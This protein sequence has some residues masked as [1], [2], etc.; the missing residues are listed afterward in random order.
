MAKNTP[1]EAPGSIPDGPPTYPNRG[2]DGVVPEAHHGWL[3]EGQRADARIDYHAAAEETE[4]TSTG[5]YPRV[6][7]DYLHRG[8]SLLAVTC[9]ARL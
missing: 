7:R 3:L 1:R 2:I 5:K 8:V 6:S 4:G 9:W